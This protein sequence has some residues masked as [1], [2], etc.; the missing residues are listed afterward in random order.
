MVEREPKRH[1]GQ[2]RWNM[3]VLLLISEHIV[4]TSV[5]HVEV[6]VLLVSLREH[7]FFRLHLDPCF[8]FSLVE[9]ELVIAF[10]PGRRLLLFLLLGSLSDVLQT[11]HDPHFISQLC[12]LAFL[13]LVDLGKR[14]VDHQEDVPDALFPFVE[15]IHE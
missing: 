8:P 14:I 2:L 4:I 7:V 13:L 10:F 15:L 11:N 6:V 9:E 5:V 3:G 1:N 12:F